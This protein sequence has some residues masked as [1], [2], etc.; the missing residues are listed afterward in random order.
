MSNRWHD[1]YKEKSKRNNNNKKN[2]NNNKSEVTLE[3]K[4]ESEKITSEDTSF[5]QEG[6][7]I[8]EGTCFYCGS[9]DHYLPDCPHKNIIQ[10]EDK[11]SKVICP[12]KRKKDKYDNQWS[13]EQD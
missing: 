8:Q 9:K 5:I 10:V 6:R 1:N 7:F 13:E 12:N 3:N 2:P 11:D 4:E